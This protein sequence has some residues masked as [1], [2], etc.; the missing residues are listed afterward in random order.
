MKYSAAFY[1]AFEEEQKALRAFLPPEHNY[2]FTWKTIQEEHQFT[3]KPISKIISTRTQSKIPDHWASELKGIITRSTGYDHIRDYLTRN[4]A[5]IAAAYLP[6]YAARAVAEH[7]MMLWTSLLRKSQHLQIAFKTFHRDSLTGREIKNRKI[8]VIG[9]G[10][11][12]SQIIDI[13]A[14]LQMDYCAVDI[15]ERD[16]LK[17]KYS[18][19]YLSLENAVKRSE[20]IASALPL[21]PITKGMLDKKLLNTAP[22]GAIFVNVGRGE[23]TFN[24][25]LLELVQSGHLAGVGLDVYNCERELAEILRDGKKISNFAPEIQKELSAVLEMMKNPSFILTP[26]NAFNT[27][28]SVLR[29]SQRTAENLKSFLETGKFLTPIDL[30]I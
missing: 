21:T 17:E 23:V 8:A 9:A 26:H 28:E 25:D 2:F 14:G 13:A 24:R 4:S 12:G 7:A 18:L 20:I 30:I 6:D 1:E 15:A 27:E 5:K 16:E 10:R 3:D 22:K 19:K 11:I 29:K